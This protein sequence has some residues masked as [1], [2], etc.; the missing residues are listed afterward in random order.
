[1]R[2]LRFPSPLR[3]FA[4]AALLVAAINGTTGAQS[5]ALTGQ[6]TFG[7]LPLPGATVTAAG[8][9]KEVVATSDADG[10]YRLHDLADGAWTIR[11][12]MLGFTP[13]SREIALPPPDPVMIE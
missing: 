7:T 3:A 8:A 4:A 1:M 9:G 2:T 11:V 12:E 5:A 13:V 6:V 10:I